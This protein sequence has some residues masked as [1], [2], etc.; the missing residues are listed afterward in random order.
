MRLRIVIFVD[1]LCIFS[2]FYFVCSIDVCFQGLRRGGGDE[3]CVCDVDRD[4]R[5]CV[6]YLILFVLNS[7]CLFPGFGGGGGGFRV[8]CRRFQRGEAH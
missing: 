1:L 2:T 6:L 3:G 7:S 8:W 4:L 5:Q